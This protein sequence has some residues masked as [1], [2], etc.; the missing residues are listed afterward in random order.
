MIC[1]YK[2][3][4]TNIIKAVYWAPKTTVVKKTTKLRLA[5]F[6][7]SNMEKQLKKHIFYQSLLVFFPQGLA[8][9]NLFSF[10]DR[11]LNSKYI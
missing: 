5:N 1:S 4:V 3:F 9:L 8:F 7:I 11:K 2:N 10:F 6:I